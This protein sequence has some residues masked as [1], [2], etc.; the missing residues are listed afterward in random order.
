M[1]LFCITQPKP[2][3]LL[4]YHD[5][6]LFECI[7]RRQAKSYRDRGSGVYIVLIRTVK[8]RH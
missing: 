8:E 2:T 1:V 4:H 7:Y 6:M 3:L 5:V